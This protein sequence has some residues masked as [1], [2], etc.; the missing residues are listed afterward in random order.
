MNAHR[1]KL[2]SQFE[3]GTPA[4][5]CLV[6]VLLIPLV[7]PYA[8]Y[9]SSHSWLIWSFRLYALLSVVVCLAIV[10][11]R[12]KSPERALLYAL[13]VCLEILVATIA[14][15]GDVLRW[16]DKWLPCFG[17]VLLVLAFWG[18]RK[19]DLLRAVFIY[20]VILSAINLF[21]LI[22]PL[23]FSSSSDYGFFG[24]KNSNYQIFFPSIACGLLLDLKTGRRFFARSAIACVLAV[25]Q[26]LMLDSATTVLALFAAFIVAIFVRLA[27]PCRFLGFSIF[28]ASL[29]AFILVVFF[30][31]HEIFAF[32]IVDV[33]GKRLDL[34]GRYEIWGQV[35]SPVDSWDFLIGR[36][37][38]AHESLTVNGAHTFFSHNMYLEI[39]LLGGLAA[40]ALMLLF[41]GSVAR[42]VDKV[43]SRNAAAVASGILVGYLVVG[44]TEA[45]YCAS[46]FLMFAMAANLQGAAHERKGRYTLKHTYTVVT[47]VYNSE[48]YLDDYFRSLMGQT[49]GIRSI[50]LVL[51]D[52]G[53]T[54]RSLDVIERWRSRYPETI[55]VITQENRGP[56]AARNSGLDLVE[57]Q[58][59]TFIDSDDCV[60]ANYLELVDKYLCGFPD[61]VLATCDVLH[62]DPDTSAM[63]Q[64][65]IVQ[66]IRDANQRFDVEDEAMHPIF[67]MNATFFRVDM[68]RK[69]GLKVDEHLRP[70]FEDGHFIAHYLMSAEKGEVAYLAQP[71]YRHRKRSDGTSVI[72]RA[73]GDKRKYSIVVRRGYLE[74]LETCKSAFGKVPRNIQ[75]TILWDVS[76]LLK[77]QVDHPERRCEIGDDGE[78]LRFRE[79]LARI[80]SY[81]DAE[82]IEGMESDCLSDSWKK[83]IIAKYK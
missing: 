72:D 12:R 24:H 83:A 62:W 79:D 1:D 56:G 27:K 52:D 20:T 8:I 44:L 33:F 34:T 31:A 64:S 60:P 65:V 2:L 48:K 6:V 37:V 54:D 25:A 15:D 18:E 78:R 36:G 28:V 13:L 7:Q 59:V 41:L 47:P 76:W 69:S 43:S 39:W 77:R 73:M 38:S 40:A 80:F 75:K 45:M 22:T 10:V 3:G 55:R 14:S 58:W 32:L 49:C 74:L 68:I 5:V 30:H 9:C 21:F 81:I 61:T 42:R 29:V 70:V 50:S 71:K 19:E 17:A 16:V 4:S 23:S 67:Y 35:L 57:T 26:L 51:V 66:H 53:S 82:T 46:F 63:W 11:M